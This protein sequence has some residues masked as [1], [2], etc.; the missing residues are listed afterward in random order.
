MTVSHAFAPR[1][2]RSYDDLASQLGSLRARTGVSYRELVRRIERDRG[3]RGVAERPTYN[4]VYRCLRPGRSRLDAELVADI[5]YAL[6]RD[7]SIAAQWRR[8]CEC[9]AA[10]RHEASVVTVSTTPPEPLS[11]FVG[12]RAELSGLIRRLAAGQSVVVS[13]MAGAGKSA[14][15]REAAHAL[16]RSG[17]EPR[18]WADLRGFDPEQPPAD[19]DAVLAAMLKCLGVRAD[20][21]AVMDRAGRTAELSRRLTGRRA[22]VVLDDAAGEEQVRPLLPAPASGCAVLVTSRRTL[23][24]LGV[25]GLPLGGFSECDAAE[26]LRSAYPAPGEPDRGELARLADLVGR[27]PLAVG[28][29]A[30]HLRHRPDW[31]LAD[32]LTRLAEL[33]DR[34]QLD[35]GVEVALTSSYNDLDA[36]T[37]RVF[38]L[39]AVHPGPTFDDHAV[40]ALTGLAVPAAAAAVTTLCERNLVESVGAGRYRLHDLVQ[41]LAGNRACDEESRSVRDGARDRLRRFYLYAAHAAVSCYVPAEA[42]SPLPPP[43]TGI[44]LPEFADCAASMR[45]LDTERPNLVASAVRPGDGLA[46]EFSRILAP[47]LELRAH[48]D[49]AL[50]VHGAAQRASSDPSGQ[51]SAARRYAFAL[52]SLNRYDEARDHLDEA[53]RRFR[54]VGDRVAE[55]ATRI[56]LGSLYFWTGR[57]AA[58]LQVDRACVTHAS[59][60]G[61]QQLRLRALGNAV[62]DCLR[63]GR[64]P[65]AV[66]AAHECLRLAA[67]TGN[68]QH[69]VRALLQ[70]GHAQLQLGRPADALPYYDRSAALAR[71]HGL[72]GHE[73]EALCGASDARRLVG[74]ASGAAATA[75]SAL[76]VARAIRDRSFEA[77]A[78]NALGAAALVTDSP[79]DAISHHQAALVCAEESVDLRQVALA[80]VGTGNGL[81]KLGDPA[82]AGHWSKALRLRAH[83]DGYEV[84]E[85]E[86]GAAPYG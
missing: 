68:S 60:L 7:A 15:A 3:S 38:R 6:T 50:A 64:V 39:L 13:G 83:L 74:D 51:A 42:P 34:G 55:I 21:V 65:E 28:L 86:R 41:V 61:H 18:L 46:E 10:R 30:S 20:R 40:A 33:R 79:V 57:P 1:A 32:Q 45:W 63:L 2:V 47:F 52:A 56:D 73:T 36:T 16:A 9:A 37:Q 75:R 17:V 49:D 76:A 19:P 85:I 24:G 29:V 14:L 59:E 12:R 26:L 35:A 81:A 25:G 43:P 27:L 62:R 48:H 84:D 22:L 82:A 5:A 11:D 23:A 53:L 72:R 54:D 71:E 8:A 80:H 69:E 67:D 66:A 58:A 31:S 70:L 78:L 77:W 4:A 44:D